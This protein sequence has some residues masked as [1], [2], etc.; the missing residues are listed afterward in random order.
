MLMN[1]HALET[2]EYDWMI[3][4]TRIHYNYTEL[5][6]IITMFSVAY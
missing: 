1:I 6:K 3:S 5:L 4:I 2:L